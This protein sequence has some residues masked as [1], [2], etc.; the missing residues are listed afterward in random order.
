MNLLNLPPPSV[1]VGVLFS[2]GLD[3]AILL[4]QLIE[5]GHRVTPLYVQS[6]L[7]WQRA[8][9]AAV[10]K[11]LAAVAAPNLAPLVP[12]ALP[13]RDVYDGH[14]SV[15]GEH[16]PD[17][18][19]PDEAVY[20]PSRN[21]LL[22][23]K[24]ALWCQLHAI[25]HLALATLGTSPFDDA[26]EQYFAAFSRL[27]DESRNGAF[28]ILRPLAAMNKTQVMTLGRGY[29]LQWTFSC[30]AP[31]GGRHCGRCNKC[32]ERMRAFADAGIDDPTEYAATPEK[33]R[34]NRLSAPNDE[35]RMSNV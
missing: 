31:I 10:G 4:S 7:F 1:P 24:T 23:V 17:A 8:E 34:I 15:T 20:L 12:L 2:G 9:A 29:P 11:Y 28:H 5:R 27:V 30:L 25:E 16:V 14:W 3:S 22:L 13:L 6:D 19:S 21:A 33:S 35:D 32:A 26:T 18:K